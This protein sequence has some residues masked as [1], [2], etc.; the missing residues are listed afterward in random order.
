[1][2]YLDYHATTPVDPEVVRAMVPYFTEKFGNAASRQYRMGWESNSAVEAAR[3]Q[4]ASLIGAEAKEIVWTSGAT[5]ANNLAL[6]GLADVATSARDHFVTLR[7]SRQHFRPAGRA[8]EVGQQEHQCA[9]LH[10]P[11]GGFQKL[12][13]I[14]RR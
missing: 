14:G 4:V 8:D 5:E 12:D 6:K 10:D 7:Q 1:M 3:A 13:Q 9:S 11:E 2:I